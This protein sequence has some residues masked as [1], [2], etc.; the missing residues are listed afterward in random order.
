MT[1]KLEVSSKVGKNQFAQNPF[2][3]SSIYTAAAA[4]AVARRTLASSAP[5][6][7]DSL[8]Y[9]VSSYHYEYSFSWY[10]H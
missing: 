8:Q 5:F 4:A 7:I 1:V 2:H 6:S 3:F 10:T 9:Q